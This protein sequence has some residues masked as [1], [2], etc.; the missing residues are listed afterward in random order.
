[1]TA[2]SLS[3]VN[4][5]VQ[6]S[7]RDLLNN[8]SVLLCVSYIQVRSQIWCELFAQSGEFLPAQRESVSK[9]VFRYNRTQATSIKGQTAFTEAT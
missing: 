7:I 3:K 2:Y 6:I 9:S 5:L 1:M 8:N 4:I